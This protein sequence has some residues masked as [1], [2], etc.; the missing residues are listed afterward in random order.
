MS[1]YF[2]RKVDTTHGPVRSAF[3]EVGATVIDTFRV[4]DDAPDMLVGWRGLTVAVEVKTGKKRE[5]KGQQERR[6]AWRG[7][8]WLVVT[9]P[10]DAVFKLVQAVTAGRA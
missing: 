2:A 7:G 9:T 8:P 5:T 6:E 1:R 4:G 10:D 3:R